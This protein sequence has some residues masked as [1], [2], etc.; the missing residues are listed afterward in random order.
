[1]VGEKNTVLSPSMRPG[2]PKLV[3]NWDEL[4]RNLPERTTPRAVGNPVQEIKAAIREEIP[5]CGSSFEYA[6]PLTE[7]VLL[8]TIAIRSNKRVV[9]DSGSMTFSDSSLNSFIKEPVRKGWEVVAG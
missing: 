1:M 8:G 5:R 6:V 9:Y 4:S 7:I 3:Y 2:K